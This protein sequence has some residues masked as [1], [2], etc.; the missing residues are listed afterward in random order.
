MAL[1]AVATIVSD[2]PAVQHTAVANAVPPRPGPRGGGGGGR[3]RVP[4]GLLP[5]LCARAEETMPLFGSQALSN[6]L[7]ALARLGVRPSDV[8]LQ[9]GGADVGQELG[10]ERALAR[11]VVRPSGFC[12]PYQR[13]AASTLPTSSRPT[14]L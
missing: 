5:A 14:P 13:R 12:A 3:V 2:A 10:G 4:Q 9:V 6:A 8:W 11:L 7:W 1:W